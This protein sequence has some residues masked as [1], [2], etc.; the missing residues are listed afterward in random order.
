MASLN[1]KYIIYAAAGAAALIAGI[2]IY[3]KIQKAK[4]KQ[5]AKKYD[6][7]AEK[8][9]FYSYVDTLKW[10]RFKDFKEKWNLKF[11]RNESMII[12]M[13]LS[14]GGCTRFIA[15]VGK[16]FFMRKKKLYIFDPEYK[17]YSHSEKMF[18]LDYHEDFVLPIKRKFP[19]KEI[20]EEFTLGDMAPSDIENAINPQ[21]LGKFLTAHILEAIMQGP[22]IAEW[23][24]QMKLFILITMII[25]IIHIVLFA[26]KT[27]MLKSVPFMGG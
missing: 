27:G 14:V 3:K 17:Y 23:M 22:Q 4:K 1:V 12:S 7:A 19:V 8:L 21:S 15:N 26:A 20:K 11:Y 25:G 10:S 2:L 18:C 13:E 24:K 9:E 6:D 16:G 5:L